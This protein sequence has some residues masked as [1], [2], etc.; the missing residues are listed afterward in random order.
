MS[1]VQLTSAAESDLEEI[2]VFIGRERASP[3][4]G[5]RVV[6]AILSKAHVYAH[7]PLLGT[8]LPELD[9]TTRA[10]VVYSYVVLYQPDADGIHIVRVIHSAQDLL[11]ALGLA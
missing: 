9:S 1:R 8:D 11:G 3:E 7:H 10:F 2:L 4:A 6:E 5:A